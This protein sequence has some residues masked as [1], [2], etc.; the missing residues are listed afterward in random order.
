MIRLAGAPEG[1]EVGESRLLV[2]SGSLRRL[3]MNNFYCS[4]HVLVSRVPRQ[5]SYVVPR[6][7]PGEGAR[8]CIKEPTCLSQLINRSLVPG[9]STASLHCRDTR[10]KCMTQSCSLCFLQ[11]WL[12]KLQVP[13]CS[14]I[15]AAGESTT[16]KSSRVYRH[17]CPSHREQPVLLFASLAVNHCGSK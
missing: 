5:A 3:G 8:S 4:Y 6:T 2:C 13:G 16:R 7:P 12:Y 15:A 1:A 14:H 17:P 9:S 10:G 11:Q